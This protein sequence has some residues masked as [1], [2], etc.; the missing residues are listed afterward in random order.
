MA[1][2]TTK[3]TVDTD[4]RWSNARLFQFTLPI[5]DTIE[6]KTHIQALE[7]LSRILT[8]V[9]CDD[10][11]ECH[12]NQLLKPLITIFNCT[13]FQFINNICGIKTVL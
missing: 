3:Q 1:A 6:Q 11:I 4:A 5:K 13:T 12:V 8:G 9:V 7:S 10:I 2:M